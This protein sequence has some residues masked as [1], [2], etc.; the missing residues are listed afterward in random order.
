MSQSQSLRGLLGSLFCV[1]SPEL[2]SHQQWVFG[3]AIDTRGYLWRLGQ[4]LNLLGDLIGF[5]GAGLDDTHTLLYAL[6]DAFPARLCHHYAPLVIVPATAPML[7]TRHSHH[8]HL[9][10]LFFMQRGSENGYLLVGCGV[11]PIAFDR[12]LA[13]AHSVVSHYR[14][15][16]VGDALPSSESSRQ[17]QSVSSWS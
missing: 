15:R 3:L 10:R 8:S 9:L 17:Q 14:M 2:L 11:T 1:Q 5:H 16:R 4:K 12:F 7:L 6:V 13:I